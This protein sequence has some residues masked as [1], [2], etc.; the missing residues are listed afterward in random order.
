VEG[1]TVQGEPELIKIIEAE[2]SGQIS[3]THHEFYRSLGITVEEKEK[4]F[5]GANLD[6]LEIVHAVIE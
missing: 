1:E 4:M 5:C 6:K 3:R 2:Q